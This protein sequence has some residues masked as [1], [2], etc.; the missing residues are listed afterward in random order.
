ML[1][2]VQSEVIFASKEGEKMSRRHRIADIT[3]KGERLRKALKSIELPYDKW[4]WCSLL[5]PIFLWGGN[6]WW[7]S[8]WVKGQD[9]ISFLERVSRILGSNLL[10]PDVKRNTV[11]VHYPVLLTVTTEKK[12]KFWNIHLSFPRIRVPLRSRQT[13]AKWRG[14]MRSTIFFEEIVSTLQI[15][16]P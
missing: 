2:S 6:M 13:I 5:S 7:K 10:G 11:Q 14:S 4:L 3:T 16:F 8:I 12:S 15:P 9:F 1:A